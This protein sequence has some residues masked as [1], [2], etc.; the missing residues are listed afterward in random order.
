M[1]ND[2]KLRLIFKDLVFLYAM[3][4]FVDSSLKEL[5]S[6]CILSEKYNK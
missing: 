6:L 5:E 2:D 4:L 1:S 3:L